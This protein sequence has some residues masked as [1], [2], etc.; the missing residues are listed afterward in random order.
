MQYNNS[1]PIKERR[2]MNQE[3]LTFQADGIFTIEMNRPEKKNAI[4]LNMY[5]L[6]AEAFHKADRDNSVRVVILQ[7]ARNIFTS[8][9]DIKDFQTRSSATEQSGP[10]ASA[11]FFEAVLALRKP[12]I[13]AV[14]G[15]AIG[16]GTTMLLHC[17][18]VY[19]GKSTVFSLP[20]VNLGL[21]PEFGSS[22]IL[23]NLAGHRRAAELF[24]LGERFGPEQARQVGIV[25]QVFDDEVLTHK[26]TEVAKNLARKSPSAL[27]ATKKLM[28]GHTA[29][30][31]REAIKADGEVFGALLK[32]REAQEAFEAFANKRAPDFSKF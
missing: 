8:G 9:N 27:M 24:M 4:T 21:C 15:Y 25:N 23:P 18:L 3:I 16:I 13:A 12:L 29:Q 11:S 6:M 20:F 14:Q 32:G 17:D 30:Q 10:P 1:K 19:A 2:E 31:I 22:F 5:K 26:V 28:K 7:G